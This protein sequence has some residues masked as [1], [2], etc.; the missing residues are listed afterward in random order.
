MDNYK[1]AGHHVRILWR[2]F[3]SRISNQ[4]GSTLFRGQVA[5]QD[6]QGLWLWGRFFYEKADTRSIREL[7]REK[8]GEMKMYYAPW[9]SLESIQ[10]IQE[11]SKE[12]EIHQLVLTRKTDGAI[13]PAP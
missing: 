11:D 12:F 1:L 3:T 2:E 4:V 8:D 7:P 5:H 10:I 6:D 9:F 13:P